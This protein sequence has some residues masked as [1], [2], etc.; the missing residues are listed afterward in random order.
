MLFSRASFFNIQSNSFTSLFTAT[1]WMVFTCFNSFIPTEKSNKG[2]VFIKILLECANNKSIC[3]GTFGRQ[4]FRKN[5]FPLLSCL[6][7]GSIYIQSNL[8][9]EFFKYEIPSVATV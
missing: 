3:S 7:D 9:C 6:R 1:T 5:T 4:S 2:E 8:D